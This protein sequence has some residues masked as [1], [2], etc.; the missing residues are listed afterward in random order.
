MQS[1]LTVP[2]LLATLLML[3]CG[4]ATAEPP[5]IFQ[6]LGSGEGLP[7]NTVMQTLQDTQ[8]FIWIATEDGLARYDGYEI[9]RYA[10]DR[11]QDDSLPGNFA[12]AIAEDRHGDLWVA[13]K[14]A[15]LARWNRRTDRFTTLR[16]NP[17]N[18]NGL[19][20]D[21]LRTLLID[22]R[23]HIWIGTTGSGLDELDPD[24]MSFRHYTHDSARGDSLSSNVVTS[25]W[26]ESD[27]QI[28]VGTDDG[29]NRL[30]PASRTFQRYRSGAAEPGS[31]S[32]NKVSAIRSDSRGRLWIGTF[33]RG[34]NLLDRDSGK[35]IAYRSRSKDPGS[36]ASDEVRALLEDRDGRLWVGTAAGVNLRDERTDRFTRYQHDAGDPSTLA[37]DHVM[38]LYQDRGRLLWVGTRAGGVSRWNPRTWYLGHERPALLGS[39]YVN[40]FADDAGGRLWIGTL[41]NGLL[42]CQTGTGSCVTLGQLFGSGRQLAD[43]RVM[44]LAMDRRGDLWIGTMSGGLSRLGVGGRLDRWRS[45]GANPNALAADGIMAVLEHSQG[46]IWLGTFGA[47]VNILDPAT[48]VFQRVPHVAGDAHSLSSPQATALAEDRDGNVW[49]GTDGGGVDLLRSDGTVAAVFQRHQGDP[50]SLGANSVYAIHVDAGGR[51]WIGTGGGGLDLVL[52]SASKP[53]SV[54]FKNFSQKDGLNSEVIYGIESDDR[55]GL[56]LSGN[57]GLVRFEP[58]TGAV[59]QFRREHGLQGDEFNFG[60]H[61]RTRGGLLAFGGSNGFNLFD[62]ARAIGQVAAPAV[63]MTSVEVLNKPAAT[64]LPYPLLEQLKLGYRDDV[65][66]FEF[67]ALDY[68]APT[69]NHYAYRL[70]GFDPAWVDL[71]Q[72]R[73]VSFTNLDAGSY[74]L[75][76]K[77]A[78]SDG[79][80]S[81]V[82]LSLPIVV[83]PAPWQTPWAYAA[84][85]GTAGLLLYG[86]HRLQRRKLTLVAEN[87]RRLEE[88]VADRTNQLR[89]RNSELDRVSKVKSDFMARMSHEIRSPMN[90]VIGT[91]E[92]L[93]RTPQSTQQSK[94]TTTARSSAQSLL[95]ILN[96]I[97]DLA[98]VES[99]KLTL[100]Q[101]PFD[102]GAVIEETAQ[103]LAPQAEAKRLELVVSAVPELDQ[104][105]LGDA[106][107]LR[108]ILTNLIGNAIK[109]TERGEITVWATVGDATASDREVTITV[110]DTGI[111]MTPETLAHV[112]EPFAQADE[113][114]TRRFGGTGLGLSICRELAALMDASVTAESEPGRGS[115]FKLCLRLRCPA[116]ESRPV[117]ASFRGKRALLVSRQPALIEAITRAARAWEMAIEPLAAEMDVAGYLTAAQAGSATHAIDAIVVDADSVAGELQAI[118]GLNAGSNAIPLVFLCSSAAE[119]RTRV[120]RIVAPKTII[121]K[122]VRCLELRDALAHFLGRERLPIAAQ[123]SAQCRQL[124]AH[125]LVADDNAVNQTVAQGFLDEMDCS[126]TCVA[127]GRAAVAHASSGA[128]DLILMD[129]QMP[130]IDGITA[131]GMIRQAEAAAGARRVPIVAVTAN[132]SES[133]RA[134]C[135]AVGMDDFLGKPLYFEKLRTTLQRWIPEHPET[136]QR[137]AAQPA[138]VASSAKAATLDVEMIAGI[139]AVSRPG[140]VSLFARLVELFATNSRLQLDELHAALERADLPAADTICHGLKGSA[141]NVGAAALSFAAGELRLACAAGDWAAITGL[142]VVLDR[143]YPAAI[144]ALEAEVMLESA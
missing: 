70:R 110:R 143:L 41:G 44:S 120:E 46:R 117:A 2:S 15:G 73:T 77:V 128:F 48:E 115:I 142:V 24:T 26:Q 55:G 65:V 118:A 104:L 95:R 87:S 101:Q 20:S 52:G 45:D 56:W 144:A 140:Q 116:S 31:L 22:T 17:A 132:A 121:G 86:W 4:L 89:E 25:L 97:L 102:L 42:R 74:V 108:Q 96:D 81:P 9:H 134:A 34:L 122:P 1:R 39:A 27:G 129:L 137:H 68:A 123:A 98:K 43:P 18:P 63:V 103:L 131:A 109:F 62:P 59:Q 64:S 91:L 58:A 37:D 33:D 139:R 5:M 92:L 72:R 76:V 124:S 69:K 83:A 94:L 32:S 114:T 125:V 105:V 8:G 13:L 11:D 40:A 71:R 35:F 28:W 112:F 6:H 38:S 16:H 51:V 12:W 47:G 61:Y 66:S 50:G 79:S 49:V 21:A 84:Y 78:T 133:H 136:S 127:D 130:D 75:E 93:Q 53:E 14:D 88:I 135:L 36:L 107:R 80:W 67:A 100:E 138:A 60:A 57:T 85:V 30:I 111:G 99:G 29:L 82:A 113:S 141:G 54:H 126:V 90:G 19:S 7:Q 106:L 23:G 119:L 10:H 3:V